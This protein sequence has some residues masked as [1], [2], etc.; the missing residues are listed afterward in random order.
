MLPRQD[1]GLPLGLRPRP[2]IPMPRCTS[3]RTTPTRPARE[4]WRR[5]TW[6]PS[7]TGGRSKPSKASASTR[8]TTSTRSTSSTAPTHRQ[9]PP[10]RRGRDVAGQRRL[11]REVRHVGSH[12]CLCP[13]GTGAQP[14]DRH[15][16]H[17]SQAPDHGDE[18]GV[19]QGLQRGRG[20]RHQLPRTP[21]CSPPT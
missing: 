3:R 12:S 14:V 2:A 8:T 13:Q 9:H 18:R 21:R 17:R 19:H 16:G 20:R 6:P 15:Q 11:R 7:L 4:S 10:G 1:R 5:A